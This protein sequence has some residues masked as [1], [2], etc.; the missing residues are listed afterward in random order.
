MPRPADI[1][2]KAKLFRGLADAS[3]LAVLE[4]LR[5]GRRCVSDLVRLTALTQPNV[6]AHLA[7]LQDCGLVRRAR[8]GRFAFYAIAHKEAVVILEQAE[9]I[10]GRVGDHVYEC[11]RYELP[12]RPRRR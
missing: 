10:L 1:H 4:A 2:L 6:S 5:G 7:C 8:E 3:R 12:R 9:A 11:T